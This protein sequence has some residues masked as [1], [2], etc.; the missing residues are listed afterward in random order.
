[1]T[2]GLIIMVVGGMTAFSIIIIKM[3]DSPVKWVTI[4]QVDFE[5]VIKVMNSTTSKMVLKSDIELVDYDEMRRILISCDYKMGIKDTFDMCHVLEDLGQLKK[6]NA[7]P[8]T[9]IWSKTNV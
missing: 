9:E 1:M 5:K 6:Y 4:E 2:L 8:T 3:S 7:G